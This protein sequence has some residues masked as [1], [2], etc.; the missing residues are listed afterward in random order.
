ML[1]INYFNFSIKIF[2]RIIND[3]FL[4]KMNSLIKKKNN[5][6]KSFYKYMKV[7]NNFFIKLKG[8]IDNKRFI[9]RQY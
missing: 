2:S 4:C 7:F 9:L 5:R 1:F 6:M 8:K 3:F